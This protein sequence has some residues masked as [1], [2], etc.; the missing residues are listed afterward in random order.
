[1]KIKKFLRFVQLD[2]IVP[3]KFVLGNI[4]WIHTHSYELCKLVVTPNSFKPLRGHLE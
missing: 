4:I 2:F 1:M 3:S